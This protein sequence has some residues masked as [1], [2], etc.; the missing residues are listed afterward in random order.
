M[1]NTQF[2]ALLTV[3]GTL[4]TALIGMIRWSVN[5]LASALDLN[6]ASHLETA[7]AMGVMST[8]LDFVYGAAREVK[9]EI[10][11]N[12]EKAD[13]EDETPVDRPPKPQG[14]QGQYFIGK[15]RKQTKG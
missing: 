4:L 2:G 1:D 3:I 5:R 6:T 9:D 12:H 13:L 8:K 15:Q 11:G 7:K 10:T 14:P